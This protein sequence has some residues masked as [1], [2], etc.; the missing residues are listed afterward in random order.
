M[1]SQLP[2]PGSKRRQAALAVVAA[3]KDAATAPPGGTLAGTGGDGRQL[4]P[5]DNRRAILEAEEA[6]FLSFMAK[7]RAADG[8][9]VKAQ[10]V[11][12][13]AK[14]AVSEILGLAKNAG[15]DKGE[16][17]EHLKAMKV[18]GVRKN[19]TEAEARRTRFRQ[20]LGLPVGDETE[21]RDLLPDETRDEFDFYGDGAAAYL[22]ND[23]NK[24]PASVPPRFVSKWQEGYNDQMSRMA[25]AMKGKPLKP[26]ATL[27]PPVQE[28]LQEG[29]A[30]NPPADEFEATAEELAA[31]AGRPVD[32]AP[33]TV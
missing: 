22:R 31:Q 20:Y 25:A 30:A 23:D 21:Q 18:K 11:L 26:K 1:A 2:T 32:H 15:F 5:G 28:V 7:L 19:L 27:A 3:V 13:T 17:R 14:G 10:A 12:D 8:E 6:Q 33:E 16:M 4:T 29:A 9:V 24:P